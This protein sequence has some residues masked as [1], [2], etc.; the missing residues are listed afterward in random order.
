[1]WQCGGFD[2][3]SQKEQAVRMVKK[4]DINDIYLLL[5]IED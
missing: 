2:T 1:M 4:M 3:V 5:G